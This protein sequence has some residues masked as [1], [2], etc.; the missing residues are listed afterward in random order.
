MSYNQPV[1]IELKTRRNT[2][3]K[4]VG[5]FKYL[6]AWMSCSEKDIKIRKAQAWTACHKM[7]KIWT[8]KLPRK[9]KIRLFQS[10]VES[11]LLYNSETWTL[12]KQLEK[13]IDGTYTRMLRTALNIKWQQHMTNEELYGNLPKVSKKIQERRLRLSGHCI[14]H[15][16]E[17][18]SKVILWDPIHGHP[19]HGRRKITYI[20]NIKADTGLETNEELRTAMMDRDTWKDF[21][22]LARGNSRPK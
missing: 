12:T 21:I 11:V 18:G 3:L 10:T 13:G 8:S 6:G 4:A 17:E 16:E 19:N 7:R 2:A 20:N 14:R 15:E 9:T 1:N 5:D 22:R